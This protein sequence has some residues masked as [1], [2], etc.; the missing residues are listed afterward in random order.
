MKTTTK[1]ITTWKN[2]TT[3]SLVVLSIISII[4]ISVSIAN[5]DKLKVIEDKINLI[6]KSLIK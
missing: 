3:L 1:K 6:Q 2:I 4:S 5:Y